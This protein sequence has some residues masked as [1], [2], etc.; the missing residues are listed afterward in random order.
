MPDFSP[1]ASN[2]DGH[3]TKYYNDPAG[4]SLA[5]SRDAEA[6]GNTSTGI[7]RV[8]NT[9]FL[10][11]GVYNYAGVGFYQISR[12]GILFDFKAL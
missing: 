9:N 10:Y 6:N 7:G 2:K 5:V 8:F 11:T 4:R 12:V 3:L 1:G